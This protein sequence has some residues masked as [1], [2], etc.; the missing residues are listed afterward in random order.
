MQTIPLA[1]I[2]VGDVAT[3][4]YLPEFHRIANRARIV[5]MC[6]RASE[7]VQA[8]AAQYGARPYTDYRQMLAE[9]EA[10]AVVN[11]TPVQLH[12]ATN[13]AALTSGRHVYSEKTVAVTVAEA[14]QL[15]TI[16]HERGLTFVCAPCVLLWPQYRQALTLIR[17]SVIGKVYAAHASLPGSQPPWGG[18]TSDPG[19]FFAR[20]CGPVKDMGVYALHALTGLLGPIQRVCAFSART[21]D[22]FVSSAGPMAAREIPIEVDTNWQIVLDHGE[23]RLT[24]LTVNFATTWASWAP[25]LELFG[26]LGTLGMDLIDV[27]AP[28][29]LYRAATSA[30]EELSPPITGRAE[31]PDHIMGVEHLVEC[32]GSGQS[33]VLSVE[34]ALHVLDVIEH[35]EQSAA[36]GQAVAV[37]SRFISL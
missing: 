20:G 24:S 12:Y 11:L 37:G 8:V 1:F 29:H 10:A 16:A 36:Q 26:T 30:W 21:L 25:Q 35:A 19:H 13:L 22:R 14:R 4:D 15:A 2:G 6:G 34:H 23:G 5:A 18:Y 7:R 17:E 28:L 9:T 32:V 3:R 31:G 27:A 33:P